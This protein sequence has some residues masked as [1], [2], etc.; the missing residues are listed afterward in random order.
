MK[1]FL[2]SESTK[3]EIKFNQTFIDITVEY[4]EEGGEMDRDVKEYSSVKIK[5][6]IEVDYNVTLKKY[7]RR[8][9]I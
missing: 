7:K 4:L 2:E 3:K 6:G 8:T 5:F 1:T 9:D